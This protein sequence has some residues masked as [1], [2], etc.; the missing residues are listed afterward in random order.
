ME[1]LIALSSK[2]RS[3]SHTP[4]SAESCF[5]LNCVRRF[6]RPKVS[7]PIPLNLDWD[8]L[9]S[10]AKKHSVVSLVYLAL[11]NSGVDSVPTAVL[12]SLREDLRQTARFNLMLSAELAKILTLLENLGIDTRALK[13]PV[14]AETLYG[15]IAMRSFSDLDLLISPHDLL[16]TKN[17]LEASGYSLTSTLHW[18]CD[19]ACFRARGC[20]LSF[21]RS[22]VSI[23]L[24]WRLMPG[25][26]PEPFDENQAW[27]GRLG[28]PV[29]GGRAWTLSREHML[30]FLCV[31]GAQHLWMRLGWICDVARMIQIETEMDWTY[32]FAQASQTRSK[33]MLS[34]GLSLAA[35]LLDGDIPPP[36]LKW[37]AS[38]DRTKK[39][40]VTVQRRFLVCAPI[41]VPPLDAFRLGAR[42]F[43]CAKDALRYM[44]EM[45][46]GP[47]E[48]E[49]R[50]LNLH[51][52]LFMFYYA[53]RPLRLPIKYLARMLGL[54][55]ELRV[56]RP[57]AEGGR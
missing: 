41:P 28:V 11:Q 8:K 6:L 57:S 45:L 39:L 22:G 50:I 49:F 53:L 9:L 42:M 18:P 2:L 12:G 29:G 34:L 5:L 17:V 3:D 24:H 30:L 13:G 25:R 1:G 38:E 47:S 20:Q 27:P 19:S 44:F 16:R 56:G 21:E 40:A 15:N 32:L 35:D 26:L 52:N 23:D 46:F 14:L 31:H 55:Q 54:S 4:E 43:D 51:P 48:V 37:L 36:A 10:L 7:A 33:R